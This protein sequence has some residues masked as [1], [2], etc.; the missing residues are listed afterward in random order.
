M[1]LFHQVTWQCDHCEKIVFKGE[2]FKSGYARVHLAAQ[3]TNGL[4]AILCTATD[5]D[6]EKRRNYFRNKISECEE[7]KTDRSRKRKQ[8]QQRLEFRETEAVA[9]DLSKRKKKKTKNGKKK[10]QPNLISFLKEADA[11]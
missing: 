10:I 8:Q 5:E 9:A 7:K 11:G 1:L 4:C 6:A 3:K 2:Q